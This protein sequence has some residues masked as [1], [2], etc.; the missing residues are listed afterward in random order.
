MTAAMTKKQ[1]LAWLRNIS[2]DM[3]SA[4]LARLERDLPWYKDMPPS[5]S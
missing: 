1:T 2:G 5:S 3:A 4:T